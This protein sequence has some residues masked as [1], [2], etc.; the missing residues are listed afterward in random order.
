LRFCDGLAVLDDT[1]S[2]FSSIVVVTGA[3]VELSRTTADNGS[4]EEAATAAVV[5]VVVVVV[6]GGTVIAAKLRGLAG[7]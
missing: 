4:K 3:R 6:A 5:V 7:Q 1:I 2:R